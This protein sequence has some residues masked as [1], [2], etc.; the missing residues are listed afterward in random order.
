[1]TIQG[2]VLGSWVFGFYKQDL[3]LNLHGA[4]KTKEAKN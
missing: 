4:S 2:K 3:G 1:M